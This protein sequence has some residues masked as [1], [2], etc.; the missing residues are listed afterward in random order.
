[1]PSMRGS[2]KAPNATY[3]LVQTVLLQD[4]ALA[5]GRR[6]HPGTGKLRRYRQP[7]QG[8]GGFPRLDAR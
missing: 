7:Q 1:M 4:E 8:A 5:P 2:R 3:A 6:A